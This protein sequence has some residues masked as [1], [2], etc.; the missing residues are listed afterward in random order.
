MVMQAAQGGPDAAEAAYQI[1]RQSLPPETQAI[2]PLHYNASFVAARHIGGLAATRDH[3][4]VK[5]YISSAASIPGSNITPEPGMIGK[6][7]QDIRGN[8]GPISSM[9]KG[10]VGGAAPVAP[11]NAT[12]PTQAPAQ[13]QVHQIPPELNAPATE[14]GNASIGGNPIKESTVRAFMA[15]HNINR[16]T[17]IKHIQSVMDTK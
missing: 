15:T 14:L 7:V 12:P 16:S 17:A 9:I 5:Q 6:S 1:Y 11:T 10:A 3:E 13:V 8:L 2:A 4:L